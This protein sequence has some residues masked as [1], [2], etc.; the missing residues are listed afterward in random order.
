MASCSS[1]RANIAVAELIRGLGGRMGIWWWGG[2]KL[3][4]GGLFRGRGGR[5][6]RGGVG[7]RGAEAGPVAARG[8]GRWRPR[9]VLVAEFSR[10]VHPR[11][12]P[13][14]ACALA[15]GHA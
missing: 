10:A 1:V 5:G 2:S 13:A 11:N 4:V 8:R 12:P 15:S 7:G 9:N 6:G 14:T 3:G